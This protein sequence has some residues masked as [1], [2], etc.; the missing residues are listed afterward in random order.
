MTHELLHGA[1]VR[2][3]IKGGGGDY[4]LA[5]KVEVRARIEFSGASCVKHAI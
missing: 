3:K 4:G 5:G 1:E 2:K